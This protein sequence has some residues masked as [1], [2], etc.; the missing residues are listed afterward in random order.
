MKKVGHFL[1]KN[2][3][4]TIVIVLTPLLLYAVWPILPTHDDWAGTTKP[5]FNPFF[6]K[7]H[8]LFFGYHWRPFDTWIGYIAGRNPQVLWPAFNHTLVVLGHLLCALA[9]FRL[10]SKLGFNNTARNIATLCFFVMPATMAT[11][12]AIDSQNQVYSLTI[13]IMAFL[14]YIRQNKYKYF[15][16]PLLIF[17]ATLF[18]ENGL[19]W[20]WVCPILAYG[21]GFIEK[22]TLKKDLFVGLLIMMT[23]A[24]AIALLP[25]DI[26]IHPEYEPGILKMV[27]N[28]VKFL[29]STFITVDYIY[30]LHHPSRNLLW[31]AISFLLALPFFYY[32]F[33]R[34]WRMYLDRQIV[35]TLI[36]LVICVGPHLG[37]VFSMMHT[38]AGLAMVAILMAYSLDYTEK[39]RKTDDVNHRK[40]LIIALL[41]W[42]ATALL[43][44]F[45][46]I[47]SSIKSGL[48][49]K[50]MAQE[51]IQKTGEPVKSVYVIIVEDDYPK[52]SSFCVIPNE[53]FGWGL[54]AAFETN[55]QWPEIIEDT[56]ISRN[57]GYHEKAVSMA[58]DI[59]QQQLYDCIWIVDH[60]QIEV[61]RD[62]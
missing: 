32:I 45:H 6:I 11:V 26:T 49:G 62:K 10:L 31:A 8:F 50:K 7:E 40:P 17:I 13:D 53:A 52:L 47:D 54:A 30:L 14:V 41:L 60:E 42:I 34:N 61:I 22:K 51:A 37:T 25:K 58:K 59:L 18:K 5:D 48:V 39:H 28:V 1:L 24:L 55:Y 44:D 20:A 4:I 2:W 46:L 38:Y 35:C 21:F 9:L 36:C 43:I 16:W 23:Y 29:F 27:K 56:F 19:M 33:I 57:A 12:T 15:L 3:S